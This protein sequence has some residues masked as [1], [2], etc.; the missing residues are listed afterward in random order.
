MAARR[1][2]APLTTVRQSRAE[3]DVLGTTGAPA[4][5]LLPGPP[6][7]SPIVLRQRT[8]LATVGVRRRSH[9]SLSTVL[10]GCRPVPQ[11]LVKRCPMLGTK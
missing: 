9:V 8:R 3:E 6:A 2:D 1:C 7:V 11:P 10:R 4:A 5:L